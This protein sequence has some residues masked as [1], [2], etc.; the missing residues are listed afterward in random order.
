MRGIFVVERNRLDILELPEPKPGPFD[1]LVETKACGICNSTDAK[2]L[3]GEFQ[4]GTYPI[5]LG[6][7]S[8]GEV[9]RVGSEVRNFK[10][11]DVVLRSRL[12]D[13]H[14]PLAGGR[15]RWGGFAEKALVTDAWAREGKD[16]NLIL[17]SRRIFYI[18]DI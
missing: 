18:G 2:I 17:L 5:L 7:E 13:E 6:H 4:P 9:I 16:I 10:V 14:V 11:G 1:A 15:S 3:E 12:E 8:V